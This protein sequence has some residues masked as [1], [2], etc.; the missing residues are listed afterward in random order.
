[1]LGVLIHD[2]QP[3]IVPD[4]ASDPRSVGFPP[5]HPPMSSMLGVPIT[6]GERTLGDLYLTERIGGPLRE[7]CVPLAIA[8]I[9]Q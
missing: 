7:H 4:I 1:M 6:L 9:D 8:P 5:N 2:G 3:L